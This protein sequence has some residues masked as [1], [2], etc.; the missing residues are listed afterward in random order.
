V[1]LLVLLPT[2]MTWSARY[3]KSL[4]ANPPF[5]CHWSILTLNTLVGVALLGVAVNTVFFA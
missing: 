3:K 4:L 1:L 2:I 5:Y